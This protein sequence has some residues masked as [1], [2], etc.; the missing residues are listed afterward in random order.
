M[1][2]ARRSPI[3]PKPAL[4]YNAG[5]MRLA[6]E[7]RTPPPPSSST[8][9]QADDSRKDQVFNSSHVL[10]SGIVWATAYDLRAETYD[11][12]FPDR[13]WETVGW[14]RLARR[15]G[16]RVVQW[17]CA[18]GELACG[19]ARRDL[20]VTGVD[21]TPEML[22]VAERRG[23]ALPPDQRPLWVE[24]DVRDATLP[25]HD[26][27]MAFIAGNAFGH[28]LTREEQLDALTTVRRHLRPGGGLALALAPAPTESHPRQ[29]RISGPARPTPPGLTLRQVVHTRYDADPRMLAV[30]EQVEVRLGEQQRMF[31][32]A[33]SLR[34]FTPDE[35]VHLL[36]RAGFVGVGMFGDFD[37]RPWSASAPQ[38]IV[39]AERPLN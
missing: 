26:Y 36:T 28:M 17:M 27:D 30:H 1:C 18:T 12:F 16:R 11:Y 35:V 23:A 14:V 6:V 7:P 25:H 29:T 19:L 2:D 33:F 38:W 13:S 39:C 5:R 9:T 34:L 22:R 24:D 3:A 31:E 37:L 21:L 8:A 10:R 20:Q 4:C 15:Y 32:Y